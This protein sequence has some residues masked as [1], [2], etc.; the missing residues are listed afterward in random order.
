MSNAVKSLSAPLPQCVKHRSSNQTLTGSSLAAYPLFIFLF[1]LFSFS[2]FLSFL[3]F[4]FF[5]IIINFFSFFIRFYS[6]FFWSLFSSTLKK[7]D[8]ISFQKMTL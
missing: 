4:F 8:A 2:F 6:S 5:V 1:I 7:V 3:S